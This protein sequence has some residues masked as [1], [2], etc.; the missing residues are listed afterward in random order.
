MLTPGRYRLNKYAYDV[1]V[2]A[3]DACVETKARAPRGDGDPTLIP[4]GYVGVVTNKTE[5]PVTGEAQGIQD[6]VL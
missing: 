6:N 4:P 2:V 3:A 5:N 1:K